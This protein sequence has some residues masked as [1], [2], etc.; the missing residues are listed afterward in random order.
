[1][2]LVTKQWELTHLPQ[3]K[4][5]RQYREELDLNVNFST[6][7]DVLCISS[8]Q[9][10]T[11]NLFA[12]WEFFFHCN[13]PSETSMRSR[14]QIAHF[15]TTFGILN[16]GLPKSPVWCWGQW[17][18]VLNRK[19][20]LNWFVPFFTTL[21]SSVRIYIFMILFVWPHFWKFT[22]VLD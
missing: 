5:T 14:L 16:C 8:L 18:F 4:G 7:Q 17:V 20:R 2:K 1:M 12:Q 6:K 9:C 3:I 13:S 22:S 10:Q 15:E 11:W 21:I 19:V